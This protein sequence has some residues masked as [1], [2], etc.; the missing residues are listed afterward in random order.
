MPTLA[1]WDRAGVPRYVPAKSGRGRSRLYNEAEV[2][3]WLVETGRRLEGGHVTP[4]EAGISKRDAV[5]AAAKGASVSSALADVKLE[6]NQAELELKKLELARARG[7][8]LE[9]T[10]VEAQRLQAI[11]AVRGALLAVPRKYADALAH[12]DA[13][14]V[15]AKLDEV[16]REVLALFAGQIEENP[17]G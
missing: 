17:D 6:K 2:R 9:R 5:E 3:A 10:E 4:S 8:V 13:S 15:A 1:K 12:R 7:E 11:E 16:M 14:A